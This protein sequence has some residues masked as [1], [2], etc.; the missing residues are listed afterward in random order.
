MFK[1]EKV[2]I[3]AIAGELPETK[4]TTAWLEAQLRPLYTEL[5]IPAGYIELL[6][7]IKE[8]R[9]WQENELLS[10][11]AVRAAKKALVL[12]GVAGSDVQ[13]LIYAGVCREHFEPATACHIANELQIKGQAV[14]HDVS[15]A[16]LGVLNGIIT[17]ANQIELGQIK[18]GVVLACESARNI[19]L[20]MLAAMLAKRE[21]DFFRQSFAVLTGGSGAVAVVLMLKTIAPAHAHELIGGVV[22]ADPQFYHLCHWGVD[23]AGRE[24]LVIDSA[25]VLKYGLGISSSTFAAYLDHLQL[26]RHQLDKV[27]CHQVSQKHNRGVLDL[28]QIPPAKDYTSYTHLGNIGAVSLPLTANLAAADGFLQKDDFVSFL[29]IGSGFNTVM[30]GLRW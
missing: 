8:R 11:G 26:Q 7:G 5:Q 27:I 6:S 22:G 28:L 12:A 17:I 13:A 21:M 2:C 30:L 23:N 18:Y 4:V 24:S 20:K 3:G 25:A 16:C 19:T 29:G 1:W 9:W 15:N 10:T 14:V